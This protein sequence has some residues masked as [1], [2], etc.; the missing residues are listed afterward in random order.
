MRASLVLFL[1]L[2]LPAFAMEAGE[3]MANPVLEARARMLFKDIRCVVCQAESIDESPA[4]LAGDM[5]RF[6]RDGIEKGKTDRAILRALQERYGDQVLMSP[7]LKLST[8][9]LW[10]APL[11][12]LLAGCV[13][14]LRMGRT[15]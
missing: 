15:Q 1:L 3:Q 10:I 4:L 6:V 11:L 12:L 14:W 7:P 13:V 5:R 8:V 9:L 2:A